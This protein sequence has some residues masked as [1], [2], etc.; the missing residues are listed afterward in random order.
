LIQLS[1]DYVFDGRST[2]PYREEDLPNPLSVYGASKLAGERAALQAPRALVVRTSWIFGVGGRNFVD[3]MA[4]LLSRAG[5][6]LRVVRD[7]VGCPTYAPFLAEAILDLGELGVEGTLHYCN[8]EPTSWYEFALAIREHLR[9]EREVVPAQTEEVPRPARRPAYSVLDVSRTE[10]VL[11]RRVEPW[12][13]GLALY[14]AE[15]QKG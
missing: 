10:A 4:G 13:Q 1:S 11:G 5:D 9:A 3:T 7:Q 6:P 2:V 15:R 12:D 8:R 14:L